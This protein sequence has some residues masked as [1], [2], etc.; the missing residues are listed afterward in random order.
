[1]D[2]L[3]SQVFAL[4]I[5]VPTP[6][7]YGIAAVW[8]G[9]E[10]SGIG[11]PLEPMLLFVGSLSSQ[12]SA[13]FNLVLAVLVT[14]L[15]CVVFASAAYMIGR[16]VGTIAITRV[17][18]FVGLNQTRAEH[19]EL[20]LRHRGAL[21][22]LI[23][24]LTPMVRTFGSF[25]MGAADIPPATFAVATFA[26]SLVYCSAWIVAGNLL[27]ANYQAP[28]RYLSGL[29]LRGVA[30]VAACTLLVVVIHHFWGRLT[31]HR[32]TAHFHRHHARVSAQGLAR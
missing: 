5:S 3:V 25:I 16:R 30:I 20:W 15:G 22:V 17:G 18:R 13:R 7:V 32:I 4:M 6:L 10:S 24:R 11:V 14:T 9:L 23:A 1:M 31:L 26:G 12:E 8:V 21:G 28:L 29:G 19:I 2:H 27:G